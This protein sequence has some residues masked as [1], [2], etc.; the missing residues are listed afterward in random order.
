MERKFYVAKKDCYDALSYD[1]L[2]KACAAAGLDADGLVQFSR[3]E[4]DG[5]SDEGFEKCKGLFYDA[6]SDEL[7]ENELDMGDAKIFAFDN[8]RRD[9][10]RLESA[11]K[12]A[13][14]ETVGVKSAKI[15]AAYGLKDEDRD[16]F[17]NALKIRFGTGEEKGKLS[18]DEKVAKAEIQKIFESESEN[19]C[20]FAQRVFN[21]NVAKISNNCVKFS[22]NFDKIDENSQKNVIEKT[23]GDGQSVAVRAFSGSVESALIKAFSVGFAPVSAVVTTC[24]SKDN[25]SCFRALE[26]AKRTADYLSRANVGAFSECFVNDGQKSFDRAVS[27]V[28]VKKLD[29]QSSDVGDGVILVSDDVKTEP[30]VFEKLRRV[31]DNP[32]VKDLICACDTL[33]NVLKQ[34]AAIDLKN[35]KIDVRAFFDNALSIVTKDVKKLVKV[36]KSENINAVEI[37]AVATETV[38]KLSGKTIFKNTIS[39]ENCTKNAKIS[40]ENVVYDK[41]SVD[42]ST[43]ALI[44]AD[45]QR[46]AVLYTL[47]KDNVAAKTGLHDTFDGKATAFDFVG[48]KYRLTKENACVSEILGD[49]SVAVS[50]ETKKCDFSG[51]IDAAVTALSKVYSS[52]AESP[53]AFSINVFCDDD[54]KAKEGLLGAMTAAK[55]LGISVS[56]VNVEKGS[57]NAI[58]V[59]ATAFTSGNGAISSTFSKK[60]KLLRIKLKNENFVDFDKITAAYALLGELIRLRKVSAATVVK[61]SLATDAII[62]CLGNGMGLEFY[63]FVGESNFEN[64]AGDLIILTNDERLMAYP[65]IETVGDVTD[66]PKFIIND[67]TLRADATVTAYNAPFAK[68]FPTETYSEGYT[69][70]LGISFTKKKICGFPVSRPKVFMPIF[71]TAIDKE[72][73]RRFRSAGARTEQVVIRNNDEKEFTK[74]VEEFSKTLKNCQILVLNDGN[75]LLN[76]LFMRDEIKAAVEEL[77]SRDGLI[78]GVG[79]GLGLLLKTGLLPYGKF[80]DIKNVQAALSENVGAKKTCGIRRVRISSNLSPWFNGVKTGDVFKVQTSEKDGRFVI[81]KALSDA[82]IVKGQVAAQYID[83]NDNATMETPYNP[84]GSAEAIEGIFSPDGRIYGRA[85]RFSMVSDNLYENV[86][87]EWDA[88]IFESGVKYFK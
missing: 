46:E 49:L 40:L 23:T 33:K 56:D 26:S 6:F 37:G 67:T 22:K 76:A 7:Y 51:G 63:G 3:F 36:L 85:T 73:A 41:K 42:K 83:L 13:C 5:L 25:E 18:F 80:T 78:L 45:R 4:I 24:F 75:L 17:E 21:E 50:S 48:G 8:I 12:I 55:N 11:V 72:I 82:L 86:P 74:S 43:L 58:T 57:S 53:A 30:E 47:T 31:F 52:G 2:V 28:G 10:E 66:I 81:S 61:E 35:R 19:H 59:V 60:G 15:V 27:V 39:N 71:D 79:Q 87:G 1:T 68:Y 16:V 88:K 29:M 44:G 9:D 34:G 64:D 32:D 20:D 54:E 84:G 69:K 14:G 62:S 70:N 38:V 65:F 77:L